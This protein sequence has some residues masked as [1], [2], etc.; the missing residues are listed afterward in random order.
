MLINTQPDRGTVGGVED[1]AEMPDQIWNDGGTVQVS[2]P[3]RT[4]IIPVMAGTSAEP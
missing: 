3:P 4:E 1:A 2:G